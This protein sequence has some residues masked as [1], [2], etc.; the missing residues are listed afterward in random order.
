MTPIELQDMLVAEMESLFY[1]WLFKNAKYNPDDPE[2]QER[3]PLRVFAQH[4]PINN[5]D[6]EVDPIPYLIVRL[7]SGDDEGTAGSENLVKVIF[8]AGIW[9]DAAEAQGHRDIAHIFQVIYQRFQENPS[10]NNKAT[11]NGE[12]HWALQ[13]DNYYP[14]Y[15]GACQMRFIIP[16]LR[17]EDP[18]A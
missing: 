11:Y 6:G 9:D 7:A 2:S 12:W 5:I 10:L 16:A 4:I 18:Y 15:F 13:E 8:I 3:V 14:F 17:R 1:D